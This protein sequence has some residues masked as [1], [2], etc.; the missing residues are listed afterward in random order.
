ME[1][2][3]VLFSV[4]TQDVNELEQTKANYLQQISSMRYASMIKECENMNYSD[5]TNLARIVSIMDSMIYALYEEYGNLV[6]VY[7]EEMRVN[8]DQFSSLTKSEVTD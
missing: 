7:F 1:N 4:Q 8:H 5:V 3:S 6:T 2:E